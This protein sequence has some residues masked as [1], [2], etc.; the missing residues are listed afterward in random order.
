MDLLEI[1]AVYISGPMTGY[2]K[3]NFP[4]FDA[5][6]DFAK[7]LGWTV[8]SPADNDR[9][10]Y[11]GCEQSPG[12]VKGDPHAEDPNKPPGYNFR[13]L[14][15][16]DVYAIGRSDAIVFLPGWEKS[17]GASIERHVADAFGLTFL[18]AA[19]DNGSFRGIFTEDPYAPKDHH[20]GQVRYA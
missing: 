2:E 16:W 9:L 4:A 6:R 8:Y 5:A 11:P 7:K 12:H 10:V 1:K 13:D 15:V 14:L 18:Y 20:D 3:F 17:T 19:I